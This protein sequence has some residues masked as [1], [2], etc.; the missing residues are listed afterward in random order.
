MWSVALGAP[1]T[2][3]AYDDTHAYVPLRDGQLV[4]VTLATGEARWAID[5]PTELRPAAGDGSV[6]VASGQSL[7]ALERDSGLVRWQASVDGTVSAPLLWDTGWLIAAVDNGDLVALRGT[8]GRE[9]WRRQLGGGI[10]IH[11][12][13]AGQRLFV[14]MADGRILG[15]DLTS[16]EQLWARAL[17]GSPTRILALD[18]LFVGS[19]DNFFY[20][21]SPKNGVVNWRWRTGADIIG[22]PVADEDRVYFLSLDHVLRALDRRSGV[23]RWTQAVPIRPM[24]GPRPAWDTLIISGVSPEILSYRMIDGEPTG[25]YLAPTELAA[26]PH[27]IEDPSP[28]GPSVVILTGDGNLVGLRRGAGSP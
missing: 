4:A 10:R 6:F 7:L 24:T 22:R 21:L 23:Q 1:S 13:I 9:I 18:D 16:G 5:R 20:S 19:T 3:P 14:P 25:F 17:G 11:P 27:V 15:L 8:D 2:W 28:E 12:S 26:P